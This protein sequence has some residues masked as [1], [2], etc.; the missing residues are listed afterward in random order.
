[1]SLEGF[2]Y[3][4]NRLTVHYKLGDREGGSDRRIFFLKAECPLQA[5]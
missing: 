1:M 2:F 4:I 5:G 3:F